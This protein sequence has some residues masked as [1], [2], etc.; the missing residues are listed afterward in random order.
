M[1]KLILAALL[2]A[3]ALPA[4]AQPVPAPEPPVLVDPQVA[5]LRDSALQ[6]NYAWNITEGLTTE[7][8]QRMAG[9]EAEARTRTWAV[10]K[11]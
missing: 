7:V 4:T 2:G 8:G 3:T 11:L 1:N 6:D 10:A 9:T 5:A